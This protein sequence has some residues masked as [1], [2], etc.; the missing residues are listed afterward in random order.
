MLEYDFE[1][2]IGYWIVM[3]SNLWERALN[4]E[5]TPLGITYRQWQVL[6]WLALDGDLTQAQLAERMRVEAPTLV[7]ILDRMERDGWIA[8]H[9]SATDRRKKLIRPTPQVQPI[10]SEIVAAAHRVRARAIEGIDPAQLR[11]VQHVLATI[12]ANLRVHQL[13]EETVT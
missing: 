13:V 8:R 6:G 11:T 9:P 2:S 3:T 12:Q 4:D 5:L 7:G 1:K 10:W